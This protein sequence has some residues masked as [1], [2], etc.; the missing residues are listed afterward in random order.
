MMQ[1]LI[2]CQER[3]FHGNELVQHNL[4]PVSALSYFQVIGRLCKIL[5]A[6]CNFSCLLEPYLVIRLCCLCLYLAICIIA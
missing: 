3:I 4:D 2:G 5:E 1:Y 6:S